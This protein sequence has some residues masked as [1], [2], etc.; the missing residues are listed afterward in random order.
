MRLLG[1]HNAC[2]VSFVF[3]NSSYYRLKYVHYLGESVP[4]HSVFYTVFATY[5][6][7]PWRYSSCRTLAASHT[8]CEVS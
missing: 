5:L 1:C 6:F 3:I 8:L 7:T 4:A 2:F